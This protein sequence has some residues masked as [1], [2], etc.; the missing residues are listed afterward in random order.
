MA[1]QPEIVFPIGQLPV[2]SQASQVE[3]NY[4]VI[5]SLLGSRGMDM[6]ILETT[7]KLLAA[8]HIPTAVL[9]GRVPF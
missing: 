2:F 1:G 5:A 9:T 6:E 8:L 3:E 7:G 4:G